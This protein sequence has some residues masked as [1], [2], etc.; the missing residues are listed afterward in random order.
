MAQGIKGTGKA[1]NSFHPVPCIIAIDQ[2]YTR[3]GMAICVNGTVK[4]TYSIEMNKIKSKTNKRLEMSRVLNKMI[5]S[6]L[7]HY[8][9]SQIAVIVERIRTFTGSTQYD[10]AFGNTNAFNGF[11]PDVI[12]AHA[13]LIS[14]IVD[15][16]YIRGIKTFSV[17]TKSWKSSVLGSSKLIFP[18]IHGVKNPQKFGSVRKAIDLGF[19]KNISIYSYKNNAISYNDD[20]A[21]AICM[22]LYPFGKPPYQLK[23]EE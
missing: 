10:A 4:K 6:C 20:V 3:T 22:S 9:P 8:N 19:E 14:C 13:S 7:K 21:D 1:R 12:K 17:A 2:S 23:L 5:D 16:A 11:R 15:T 18:P